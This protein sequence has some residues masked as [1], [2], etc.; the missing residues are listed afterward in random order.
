MISNLV[1]LAFPTY[2]NLL[3]NLAYKFFTNN[4]S[5]SITVGSY[6]FPQTESEYLEKQRV[7]AI[8]LSV[9]FNQALIFLPATFIVFI[10]M[11]KQTKAKHQQ[12]ISGVSIIAYCKFSLVLLFM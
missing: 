7:S 3:S 11:E 1:H 9:F 4:A 10:V 2:L 12:L 5:G 6:P 8:L